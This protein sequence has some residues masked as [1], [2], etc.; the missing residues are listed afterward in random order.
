M[1]DITFNKNESLYCLLYHYKDNPLK[2]K[3][4]ILKHGNV[5][6]FWVFLESMSF[7]AAHSPDF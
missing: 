6:V 4:L 1:Q 5:V 3:L 2:N 7:I